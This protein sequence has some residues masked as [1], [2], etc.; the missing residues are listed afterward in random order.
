MRLNVGWCLVAV[1]GMVLAFVLPGVGFAAADLAPTAA[2]LSESPF[3]TITSVSSSNWAGYAALG[4]TGTVTVVSGAWTQPAVSCGSGKTTDVATWVGIDGYSSKTVEQ[5]GTSGD[6]T[7]GVAS[8]YA[9]YEFYPAA[10]VSISSI[11]V[12][13]GD[14]I[15]ASVTYSG[16]K[17]TTNLTDG[18]KSFVKTGTVS[19]AKRTSAECIVERDEVG[20]VLNKL[21]KFTTDSFSS[22]T[23]TIS[24]TTG[25]VGSFA[26]VS[27]I[28]MSAGGKLLASTGA[29]TSNTAFTVTWKAYS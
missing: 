20:G 24:G 10:S 7:A 27:K 4:S 28:N 5:T 21:S 2:P 29:L 14:K 13:A 3:G 22:C 15:T 26:T 16:G 17:F 11:T 1:F 9:W 25:G 18:G 8:Y 19:A 23:A 12:H 6:C